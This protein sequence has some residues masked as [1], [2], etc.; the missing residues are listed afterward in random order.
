MN[1]TPVKKSVVMLI[2]NNGKTTS[3]NNLKDVKKFFNVQF[4]EKYEQFKDT[5]T[6][7][8]KFLKWVNTETGYETLKVSYIKY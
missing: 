4:Y 6:D 8:N 7:E 2:D 5:L 1:K 3:F